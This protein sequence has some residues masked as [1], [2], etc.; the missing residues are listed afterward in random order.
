MRGASGNVLFL[1]L[2]AVALFAALS[3]AVTQSSKGGGGNI[4]RDKAKLIASEIVQYATQMEQTI[5][6]MKLINKCA[7]TQISFENSVVAGYINA[8][9]P[10]DKRCHVF[11][12][13][14]GGL[15]YEDLPEN[16]GDTGYSAQTHY[17]H[18][19]FTSDLCIP[20]QGSAR[21]PCWNSGLTTDKPIALV[22]PYIQEEICAAINKGQ[23]IAPENGGVWEDFNGLFH[24][25][26]FVGVFTAANKPTPDTSS[27]YPYQSNVWRKSGF[28]AGNQANNPTPGSYVYIHV[29]VAR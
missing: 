26:R 28:C 10:A 7:D 11:D 24:W 25:N 8:N 17:G 22:V 1:I 2:I 13:N 29:L 6:R 20:T 14:G 18:P 4:S 5:S 23:D 3:Y 21:N 27:G 19:F 15:S 16:W 9:A 12:A